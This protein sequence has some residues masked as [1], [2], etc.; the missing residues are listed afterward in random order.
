MNF[1][2]LYFLFLL[3]LDFLC[4]CLL[5]IV[6]LLVRLCPQIHCQLQ[7]CCIHHRFLLLQ[8]QCLLFC[9][10]LL[11]DFCFLLGFHSW[12]FLD[13]SLLL[14]VRFC[15]QIRCQLQACCT[16]RHFLLP[17]FGAGLRC[18]HS[19]SLSCRPSFQA[20]SYLSH[21]RF[22]FPCL[23][24]SGSCF[25]QMNQFCFYQAN[26]FCFLHANC[27]C[28][29]HANCFGHCFLFY[30]HHANYLESSFLRLNQL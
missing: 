18:P 11:A 25:H 4:L 24:C 8:L 17:R 16:H 28:F 29:L 13:F 6:F 20:K 12:F 19:V 3:Y 1:L 5:L 14:F 10:L 26:C 22:Y 7:A 15:L 21:L 2:Y 30:F 9:S 27:F 23:N